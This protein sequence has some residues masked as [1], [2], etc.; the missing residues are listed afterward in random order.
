VTIAVNGAIE[1]PAVEIDWW[2][3]Y[4]R[5]VF[6][7]FTARPKE[8]IIVS[9]ERP[10][11]P[12]EWLPYKKL[13]YVEQYAS[14]PHPQGVENAYSVLMAL[15]AAVTRMNAKQVTIYGCDMA[16]NLDYNGNLPEAYGRD[17]ETAR[18]DA[19][20]ERERIALKRFIEFYEAEFQAT[21]TI[22]ANSTVKQR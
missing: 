9:F 11:L 19:R 15:A 6:E 3:A 17:N 18:N 4:D 13:Y 16:G 10:R 20:W 8:G 21:T 5:G 7:K 12:R 1:Y 2:A 22:H 14:M